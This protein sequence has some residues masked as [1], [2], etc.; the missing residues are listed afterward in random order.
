VSPVPVVRQKCGQL[1]GWIESRQNQNIAALPSWGFGIGLIM[2][3]PALPFVCQRFS[4]M[5]RKGQF[6]VAPDSHDSG[7][8]PIMYDSFKS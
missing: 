3:D 7:G 2:K 8:L 5:L 4:H 6:A 1:Q